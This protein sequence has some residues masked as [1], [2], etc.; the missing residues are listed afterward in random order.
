MLNYQTNRTMIDSKIRNLASLPG[1]LRCKYLVTLKG[2]NDTLIAKQWKRKLP[3]A[4]AN[5]VIIKF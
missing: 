4:K 2:E 3:I 5:Q 1:G